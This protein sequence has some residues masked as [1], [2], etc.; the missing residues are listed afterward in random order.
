MSSARNKTFKSSR[1]RMADRNTWNQSNTRAKPNKGIRA[2]GGAR[3]KQVSTGTE[4]RTGG[5]GE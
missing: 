5:R 1:K 3:A 2:L 4:K